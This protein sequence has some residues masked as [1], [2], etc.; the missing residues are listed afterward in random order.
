MGTKELNEYILNF[1]ND[2]IFNE[3]GVI[4]KPLYDAGDPSG[5]HVNDED[6]RLLYKNI[7]VFLEDGIFDE[8]EMEV[9]RNKRLRSNDS[10]ASPSSGQSSKQSKQN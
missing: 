9:P 2:E 5:V 7:V 3:D 10:Q 6:A 1:D 8:F 4:A